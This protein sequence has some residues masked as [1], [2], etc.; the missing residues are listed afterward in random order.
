MHRRLTLLCVAATLMVGCD[1]D[2]AMAG[3]SAQGEDGLPK[4]GAV[5]GSVTGMP[6]PGSISARPAAVP[7]PALIELP[8]DSDAGQGLAGD[9]ELQPAL[10]GVPPVEPL[11]SR[12]PDAVIDV[13]LD[14]ALPVVPSDVQDPSPSQQ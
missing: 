2:K 9:G 14:D 8:G 1:D 10:D 11:D 4:P 13:P 12:P 6:N 5:N 7:A 3:R